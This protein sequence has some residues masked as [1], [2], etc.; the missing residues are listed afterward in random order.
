MAD[1]NSSE[2]LKDTVNLFPPDLTL[3]LTSL[4]HLARSAAI[5]VLMYISLLIIIKI[6]QF[7]KEFKQASYIRKISRNIEEINE[8]LKSLLPKKGK[9][10]K[11]ETK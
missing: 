3:K 5:L 4:I 11:K 10:E 2:L 8:N 1:I 6:V 7:I 9:G